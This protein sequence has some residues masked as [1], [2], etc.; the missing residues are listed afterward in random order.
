[1]PVEWYLASQIMFYF[2]KVFSVKS[3]LLLPL[4]HI[5]SFYNK[6]F[7]FQCRELHHRKPICVVP[8]N[9]HNPTVEGIGNSSRVGWGVKAP[10]NSRGDEG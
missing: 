5:Y 6:H 4:L 8:E 9:I 3:E 2:L 7:N 10:G 1:M